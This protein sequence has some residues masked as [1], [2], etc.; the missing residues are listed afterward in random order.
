MQKRGLKK[1]ITALLLGY[2]NYSVYTPHSITGD[3]GDLAN[4]AGLER[5]EFPFVCLLVSG[6]HNLLLLVEGVG[7][8]RQLGTTLDDALG[9]TSTMRSYPAL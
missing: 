9:A 1:L 8:Y 3:N 2:K 5:P 6:G 4:G 7:S